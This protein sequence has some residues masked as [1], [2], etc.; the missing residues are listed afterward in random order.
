MF[1]EMRRKNKEIQDEKLVM[2]ILSRVDYGTLA[3][4]GENGYPYSVPVNHVVMN[5]KIYFHCATT[6]QKLDDI[7]NNQK[8]S[9]SVVDY[10]QIDAEAF[11]TIYTSVIA[12]GKAHI[13][14][15][16]EEWK[17]ALM[18]ISQRFSAEF[19]EKAMPMIERNA[20]A[21]HVVCIE[22]EDIK[23]KSSRKEI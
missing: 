8:V 21:T 14:E 18:E 3:T 7:K 4:I 19:I 10:S 12:F 20:L 9:F 2:D 17:D 11:S 5:G 15:D 22:I 13:V 6:G 16:K 1:R 23:G